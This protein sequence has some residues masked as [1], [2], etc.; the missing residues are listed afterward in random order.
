M[1]D[2][3]ILAGILRREGG[4][5]NDPNDRG[6]CTNMGITI[7]TLREWRR[8]PV[9]C[10]DVRAITRTEACDIYRARYLRPFD[11]VDEAV[12]GQV[13]D[14]AVNA[15]VNRARALLAL[16]QQ[17]TAR[18]L[19]TQLVI[20][21]LKHYARIVHGDPSQAEYLNGWIARAVEFL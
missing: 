14:I 10:D 17:Q 16:A 2:D 20:E 18:P 8:Q 7:Q 3:A 6:R 9:T 4:Y 1:T 21:R 13:I 5:V 11:G 12:K 19:N 15:G